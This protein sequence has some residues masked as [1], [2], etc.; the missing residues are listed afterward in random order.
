MQTDHQSGML[1]V[2]D[3]LYDSVANPDRWPV[4]LAAMAR[5]MNAQGAQIAHQDLGNM[6]LSFSF[7]HGYDW[8]P[9]HYQRY[10]ALM[11]EDPRL[12]HFAANP[13]KAVHCRTFLTDEQLY[14]SRVYKEVLSTG[15]VEYS[16]GV[17]MSED[18]RTLSY[19]LVLRNQSQP[20]FDDT[21]CA[22]VDQII[23]HM[24]RAIKLQR[25]IHTIVFERRIAMD[26]L[27]S[28]AVGVFVLSKDGAIQ[29]SNK[30]GND[31]LSDQDGLIINDGSLVAVNEPKGL[32]ADAALRLSTGNYADEKNISHA[33][34]FS[35]R[36]GRAPYLATM[37]RLS[38]SD[39][40]RIW[41]DAQEPLLMIVVRDMERPTETRAE[42]LQRLF[43]L[44]PAQARLAEFLADGQTLG[45]VAKRLEIT[46]ASA[47]QYCKICFQKMGVN[48]QSDLVRKVLSIPPAPI[49]NILHQRPF[50][51]DGGIKNIDF[52]N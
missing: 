34:Q 17:N 26:S 2:V 4:F 32:I 13:F 1:Q 31:M 52:S 24:V 36:S 25:D 38:G 33:F 6:R 11:A 41:T 30:T 35:R 14:E 20:R 18:E 51:D 15:G 48:R 8:A 49:H 43:G 29:F 10:E 42:V 3:L 47:R 45:E 12:P 22:V 23:P 39:Q 19:F 28:M 27:N 44:A 9:E 16:M 21:D 50:L 40:R 7:V 5:L 37:T 46:E